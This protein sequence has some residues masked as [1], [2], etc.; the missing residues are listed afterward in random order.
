MGLEQRLF[1]KL[2]SEICRLASETRRPI[3]VDLKELI[4]KEI[5]ASIS[6]IKLNEPANA[7]VK[8]LTLSEKILQILPTTEPANDGLR[9]T[10]ICVS[11]G[12][13]ITLGQISSKEIKNL[14]TALSNLHKAGKIKR[15]PVTVKNKYMVLRCFEWVHV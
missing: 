5:S 13:S 4:R 7:V 15:K 8:P 14:Q 1:E 3:D 6:Q 9:T 10:D 11:W 2:E 12:L